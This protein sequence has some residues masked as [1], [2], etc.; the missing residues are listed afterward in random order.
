[1][2]NNQPEEKRKKSETIK[3]QTG[4]LRSGNTSAIIDT[5]Q[6]I[7]EKGSIT[8]LPE[9]FDLLLVSDNE[10]VIMACTSLLNDLKKKESVQYLVAALKDER[11][12]P[13]RPILVS[14]C[15][16]NG[17][18]YHEEVLLFAE[19]LLTDD[20]ATA[21][22]AFTV[23]ENSLGELNDRD[24][25]ILTEKLSQSI[26]LAKENKRPLIR[27]LLSVIKNY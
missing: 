18:D 6:E 5:I 24:I 11:Y 20:Y 26:D 17:L 16:Q 8:I 10:E 14:A 7:R 23:I 9:L 21:V 27:E 3:R 15:W 4:I 12:K 1:M 22:E 2:E 13:V 25:L 19:I